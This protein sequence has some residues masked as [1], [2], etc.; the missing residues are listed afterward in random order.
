M[1]REATQK[2]LA[3]SRGE[4]HKGYSID[5][6]K[7]VWYR[8]TIDEERESWNDDVMTDINT[9]GDY[10]AGAKHWARFEIL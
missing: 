1:I 6:A 9:D 8:K 10:L 2:R 5:S 3:V 7:S 4:H